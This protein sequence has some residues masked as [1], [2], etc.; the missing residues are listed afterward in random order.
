LGSKLTQKQ[1][2]ILDKLGLPKNRRAYDILLS[3]FTHSLTRGLDISKIPVL[4]TLKELNKEF[5]DIVLN[6]TK[7]LDA[8]SPE[9]LPYDVQKCLGDKRMKDRA[10]F[11]T[12]PEAAAGMSE[13]IKHLTYGKQIICDPFCGGGA[14]IGTIGRILGTDKVSKL[15]GFDIEPISAMSAYITSADAM[16]WDQTRVLIELGDAFSVTSKLFTGGGLFG[17]RMIE[18][19]DIIVTNPPYLPWTKVDDRTRAGA[20]RFLANNGYDLQDGNFTTYGVFLGDLLLKQGGVYCIVLSL[21]IFYNDKS[22]LILD[23]FYNQYNLKTMLARS[24]LRTPYSLSCQ[25]SDVLVIGKKEESEDKY[26]AGMVTDD[27][28]MA[29]MKGIKKMKT[30][31]GWKPKGIQSASWLGKYNP[32]AY[33]VEPEVSEIMEGVYD[34]AGKK[35]THPKEYFTESPFLHQGSIGAP[36]KMWFLPNTDWE[37]KE[38]D[39]DFVHIK[40]TKYTS[41]LSIPRSS[42][43]PV[44]L[45]PNTSKGTVIAK[46]SHYGLVFPRFLTED[47]ESYLK[48]WELKKNGTWWTS[49]RKETEKSIWTHA[50]LARILNLAVA[51]YAGV[52]FYTEEKA[53]PVS[54]LIRF[55]TGND[56]D[57]RVLVSWYN[58]LPFMASLISFGRRLREETIYITLSDYEH[59]PIPNI[60]MMSDED[61]KKF[62]QHV[63]DLKEV[64]P[65]WESIPRPHDMEWAKWLGIEDEVL[66]KLSEA[67]RRSRARWFQILNTSNAL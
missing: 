2:K 62:A 30:V 65:F 13:A 59:F 54:A 66:V 53:P 64:T 3:C 63:E 26:Y 45:R 33:I 37:V 18:K 41:M 24:A 16:G 4:D 19:P 12:G 9:Q 8:I 14:L 39:D 23:M 57:D 35:L 28:M 10:A 60:S 52:S 5:T 43:V 67:L 15:Y 46:P 11:F 32:S 7:D 50:H 55:T 20:K 58:S 34:N 51:Y 36:V 27:V 1:T 44:F 48:H 22:R 17:N 61:K 42:T 21:S 6:D 49:Y 47:E 31:K 29:M 25:A 38:V 40:S 56:L